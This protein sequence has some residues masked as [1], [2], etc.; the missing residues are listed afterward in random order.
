MNEGVCEAYCG[1][2]GPGRPEDGRCPTCGSRLIG[3]SPPAA[4]TDP[5]QPDEPTGTLPAGTVRCGMCNSLQC[6]DSNFCDRCGHP[7]KVTD[8]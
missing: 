2:R 4:Q 5:P 7:L 8:L 1:Y 6:D 3:V